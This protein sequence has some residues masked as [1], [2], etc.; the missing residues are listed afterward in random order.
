MPGAWW[1]TSISVQKVEGREPKPGIC[2]EEYQGSSFT[3]WARKPAL[4]IFL[5]YSIT[6]H[7]SSPWHQASF[8]FD[9]C[10]SRMPLTTTNPLMDF[11]LPSL[12]AVVL[13]VGN[14]LNT[15]IEDVSKSIRLDQAWI[16]VWNPVYILVQNPSEEVRTLFIAVCFPFPYP[17]QFP[18]L[19]SATFIMFMIFFHY[20]DNY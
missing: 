19:Y 1:K 8:P 13:P 20:L 14:F 2:F 18:D 11:P 12:L 16:S 10:G 3:H 4:I 5:G 9:L 15:A 7:E 6:S 17:I